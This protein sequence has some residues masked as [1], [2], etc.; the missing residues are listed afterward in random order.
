MHQCISGFFIDFFKNMCGGHSKYY[1]S[2]KLGAWKNQLT[3]FLVYTS[4][5]YSNCFFS[6]EQHVYK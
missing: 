4:L 1:I 6:R 3:L 2:S 5:E